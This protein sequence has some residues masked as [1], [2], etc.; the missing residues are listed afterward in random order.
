MSGNQLKTFPVTDTLKGFTILIVLVNH[1]L[2]INIKGDSSGFANSWIAVFF[3]LSGYGIFYS[4]DRCFS[5][6]NKISLNKIKRFYFQ[7]ATRIFPLLILSCLGHLLVEG[8][9]NGWTLLGIHGSGIYWFIPALIHCY[10]LSPF[11]YFSIKNKSVLSY[12]FIS[13]VFFAGNYLF[14]SGQL[15][16]RIIDFLDF[17]NFNWKN[18]YL[19]D[20]I[21]FFLAMHIPLW[22]KGKGSLKNKKNVMTIQII[23]VLL[24]LLIFLEMVYVKYFFHITDSYLHVLA[25][26]MSIFLIM[27]FVVV[28]IRFE[29]HIRLVSFFGVLSYPL[30][31]FH[32]LFY[33]LVDK[34]TGETQNSMPEIVLVVVLFPV[35]LYFCSKL[36]HAVT[37]QFSYRL[38]KDSSTRLA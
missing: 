10:L 34:M 9:L 6:D 19:L 35:F 28:C 20:I 37:N 23:T 12:L 30:Y 3:M 4:L 29:V 8:K 32:M 16:S 14:L 11:L 5:G 2:N 15:P 1:F 26:N 36:E 25:E 24:F 22:Q 27:C 17:L 33:G 38:K 7:R 13:F 18:N 31:L 21:V